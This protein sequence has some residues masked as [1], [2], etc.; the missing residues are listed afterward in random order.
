MCI[1]D[2]PN[3]DVVAVTAV[4]NYSPAREV[5]FEFPPIAGTVLTALNCDDCST[6]ITS[7]FPIRF[8]GATPGSTTLF[9]G[10]NGILSFS[11]GIT[12]FT[13][14]PLPSTIASTVVA[15]HWDDPV[16]YT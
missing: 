10:S 16:S 15:P 8:G 14:Q 2:S 11:Q 7:P 9:I 5:P 3:G 1:R 13:N 4:A 6:S 12:S